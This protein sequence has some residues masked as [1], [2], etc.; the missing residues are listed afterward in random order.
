MVAIGQ[1]VEVTISGWASTW[2]VTQIETCPFGTPLPEGFEDVT[3]AA[4]Q[5]QGIR[6]GIQGLLVGRRKA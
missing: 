2:K 3:D 6:V 4:D 1:K 5:E